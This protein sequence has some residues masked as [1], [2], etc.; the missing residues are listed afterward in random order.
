MQTSAG[1]E[2]KRLKEEV[3]LASRLPIKLTSLPSRVVK[4]KSY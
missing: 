3:K 2:V 1:K 4:S